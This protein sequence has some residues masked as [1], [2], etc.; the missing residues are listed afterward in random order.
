MST[1]SLEPWQVRI[2]A[3]NKVAWVFASNSKRPLFAVHTRR[4]RADARRIIAC[5]NACAGLGTSELE[6]APGYKA[7]IEG[8][9]EQRGMVLA[10]R[11]NV[12]LLLSA[13]ERARD[14]LHNDFEPDNQSRAWHAA[15][16]AIA[17]VKGGDLKPSG[18]K[19]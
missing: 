8:F 5:V 9:H 14:A 6:S 12:D 2:D 16:A 18:T 10:A 11:A 15:N 7:A 17:A 1:N 3:G 19:P 13:L 4:W